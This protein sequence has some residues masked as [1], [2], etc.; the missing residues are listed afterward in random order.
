[1][2]AKTFLKPYKTKSNK[3]SSWINHAWD[4]N[5]NDSLKFAVNDFCNIPRL[6]NATYWILLKEVEEVEGFKHD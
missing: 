2:E 6:F 4:N 5:F 3:I 1:L